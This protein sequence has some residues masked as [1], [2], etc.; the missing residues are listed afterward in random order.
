[1]PDKLHWTQKPENRERLIAQM[2]RANAIRLSRT[3]KKTKKKKHTKKTTAHKSHRLSVANRKKIAAG[4]RASY[5]RRKLAADALN[6]H[7]QLT[8]IPMLP[9][10][11]NRFA[12]AAL[13][14]LALDGARLR[15]A[16]L[17]QEREVL[18]I[19]LKDIEI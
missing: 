2:K 9:R 6:G 14:T 17:E 5:A 1:M 11:G 7:V 16:A 10:K 19:F 8:G 15:L 4:M 12:R 18:I 3:K 13:H